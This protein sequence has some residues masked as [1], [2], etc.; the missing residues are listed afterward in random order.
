[1][2][3]SLVERLAAAEKTQVPD[4]RL[5][6]VS[7]KEWDALRREAVGGAVEKEGPHLGAHGASPPPHSQAR[8]G[9]DE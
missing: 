3:G 2:A 8:E 5:T 4:E 9:R 1:M 7:P 6:T